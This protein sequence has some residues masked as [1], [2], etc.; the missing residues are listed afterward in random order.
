MR[1]G[2]LDF[3][4]QSLQVGDDLF[5]A[6][7]G[8]FHAVDPLAQLGDF[9]LDLGQAVARGLVGLL[10]QRRLFHQVA[11][12]A[13]FQLVD[14]LG[15]R[16]QLHLQ[17]A[18]CLVDQIDG[19]VRKLSPRYVAVREPRR[20]HQGIVADADAVVDLVALFQAAQNRHCVVH[21]WLAHQYRLKPALQRLVL[22]DVLA[23]FVERGGTDAAQIAARQGRLEH[24][25]GVDRALRRAGADQGVQLVD[26][27]NDLAVGRSDLLEYRFEPV[28]ELAAK[29]GSRHQRAQI[30]R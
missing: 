18:G 8:Q 23:V 14:W 3:A 26:E 29:L 16:F 2:L 5:F 19:L 11:G 28:L 24:V 21:R 25:G 4:L 22:L 27:K 10:G 6:L 13:T 30:E 17:A 1:L 20:R 9:G 7:P 12:Q 15:Q